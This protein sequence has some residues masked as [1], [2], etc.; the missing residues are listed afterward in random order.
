MNP[1]D[2][3]FYARALNVFL[4]NVL[5]MVGHKKVKAEI[6]LNASTTVW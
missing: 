2:Q 1:F 5:S 4:G 3:T 6:T